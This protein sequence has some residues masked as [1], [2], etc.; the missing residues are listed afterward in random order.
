[1]EA[2]ERPTGAD[3]GGRREEGTATAGDGIYDVG[4]MAPLA[5]DL[6]YVEVLT[7][8][9]DWPEGTMGTVVALGP[10]MALVEVVPECEFDEDGLPIG[11]ADGQPLKDW[12]DYFLDV[13]YC[14][15]RVVVADASRP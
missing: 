14:D 9:G 1:M 11:E 15:L 6:D 2:G 13:P 4:E 12:F 3:L 10:T 7:A 8:I 5:R